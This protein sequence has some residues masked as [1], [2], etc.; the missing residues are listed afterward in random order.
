MKGKNPF[1]FGKR[2]SESGGEPPQL[3]AENDATDPMMRTP[4]SEPED[5]PEIRVLLSTTAGRVESRGENG[6]RTVWIAGNMD[7]NALEAV[8]SELADVRTEAISVEEYTEIDGKFA[9]AM[10]PLTPL[11]EF[12][13]THSLRPAEAFQLAIDLIAAIAALREAGLAPA[14]LG[15]E[16]LFCR[17]CAYGVGGGL[18]S[19]RVKLAA[20]HEFVIADDADESALV[21][22]ALELGISL[23]GS[24]FAAPWHK[25]AA[26]RARKLLDDL[27]DSGDAETAERALQR[28]LE[29]LSQ[30]QAAL[31]SD[32]GRV[33]SGNEDSGIVQVTIAAR[34]LANSVVAFVADGMGGHA[35][36]EIASR[37]ASSAAEQTLA[38][39]RK[40]AALGDEQ[41][42]GHIARA[43]RRANEEITYETALNPS[44]VGM[45]TTLTGLLALSPSPAP[46]PGAKIAVQ[47]EAARVWAANL[48]DSRTS[49]ACGNRLTR[50]SRDHSEVQRML[51]AGEIGEDE[52]FAHPLK[53]IISKCLG[54]A[55]FGGEEPDVCALPAGPGDLFVIASDGLSDMLRDEEIYG[56]LAGSFGGGGSLETAAGALIDAANEAGGKDNITV[57]LVYFP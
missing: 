38:D 32:V 48:G 16:G 43:Y 36:G 55:Q 12:L 44:R 19:F 52:A 39:W 4:T 49:A 15:A 23:L 22:G 33:R 8:K 41:V 13:E 14:S 37:I 2:K 18:P 31:A 35:A 29:G 7:E 20:F 42:F 27:K 17:A 46:A 5:N 47:F 21:N 57:A 56:I 24:D 10:P 9:V 51:D 50:L 6:G 40:S 34:P 54:G 28:I 45:G 11:R 30:P 25:S 1:K 26:K 3:G 53:N